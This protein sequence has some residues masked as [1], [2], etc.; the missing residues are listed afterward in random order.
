MGTKKGKIRTTVKNDLFFNFIPKLLLGGK[1]GNFKR[2]SQI[3]FCLQ[4][5][6]STKK[7]PLILITIN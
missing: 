6:L 2:T 4:I 7:M 1:G 5:G 3:N